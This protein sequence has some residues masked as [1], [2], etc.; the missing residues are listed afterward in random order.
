[1][2]PVRQKGKRGFKK[3]VAFMD[4]AAALTGV[5]KAIQE[6]KEGSGVAASAKEINEAVKAEVEKVRNGSRLVTGKFQAPGE[7]NYNLTCYCLCDSWI[8][9]DKKTASLKI[10]I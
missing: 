2:R 5:S 3:K 7:G 9:R 1:M 10:K 8:G 6:S 4:E